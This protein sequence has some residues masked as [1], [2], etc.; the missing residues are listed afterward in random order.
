MCV[1]CSAR[2]CAD[3]WPAAVPGRIRRVVA[4]RQPGLR[5]GNLHRSVGRIPL[6]LH[7]A[8]R[9]G[10]PLRRSAAVPRSRIR[11]GQSLLPPRLRSAAAMPS[12]RRSSAGAGAGGGSAVDWH[13]DPSAHLCAAADCAAAR[14]T[15][16]QAPHL[17]GWVP[18]IEA[19]SRLTLLM[20]WHL[21]VG[22]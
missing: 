5:R 16:L 12:R 13:A 9:R 21:A 18:G 22:H 6:P 20:F 2:A 8:V 19:I 7:K 11:S 15:W 10:A 14:A 4:V 1:S 3:S 17:P